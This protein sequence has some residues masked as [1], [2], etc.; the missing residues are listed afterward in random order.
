MLILKIKRLIMI[1][2][3]KVLPLALFQLAPDGKVETIK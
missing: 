3:S 2:K 1:P